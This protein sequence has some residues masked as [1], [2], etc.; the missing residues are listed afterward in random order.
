M[1][2]NQRGLGPI[3][4]QA[5]KNA[6]ETYSRIVEGP[7]ANPAA[8]SIEEPGEEPEARSNEPDDWFQYSSTRVA[9]AGYDRSGHR[10][11]VRW[12][13]PGMPYVYEDVPPNVWRD[14][15][16][17]ASKGKFVNRRLNQFNYHPVDV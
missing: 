17:S 4:R 5:V 15:Q 13:K 7:Q 2:R 8:L 1:P 9:E 16:R 6:A 11:F 10:L 12:V 14:F 3:G